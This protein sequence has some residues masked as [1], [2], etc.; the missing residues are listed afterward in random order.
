MSNT[1]Y[2]NVDILPSVLSADFA[3]LERDLKIVKEA[4]LKKVHVDIMDGMFVP[5]I[6]LGF[7]VIASMRKVTDLYFDVHMMVQDPGRYVEEVAKAGADSIGVHV[8]ACPHLHRTVHQIRET[9]KDC[10]V[11]LNPA[12]NLNT[13]EYVLGDVNTVLLMTVNPGFGGQKYISAMTQKIRD[14]KE[15]IDKKNPACH[16]MVDGG[17]KVSNC[18]E[19][20][21]AGADQL[22]AGSAVF[23]GDIAA[24][25][26]AFKKML[27]QID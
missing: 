12:T 9:G 11:V 2:A 19:V 13:L 15:M 14:L 7:P 18:L 3:N 1:K 24:N 23:S 4:G 27:G 21:D 25:I 16:I 6:S 8:E 10:C 26:K 20:A 17:I 22:V 5:S